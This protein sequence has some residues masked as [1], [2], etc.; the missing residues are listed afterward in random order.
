MPKHETPFY[1]KLKELYAT[2][3]TLATLARAAILKELRELRSAK[4]V[5]D[6]WAW[7]GFA[8]YIEKT[9]PELEVDFS[10]FSMAGEG[11]WEDFDWTFLGGPAK[12]GH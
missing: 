7:K 4:P 8:S 2:D 3:P 1:D 6:N 9:Y 12:I 5:T 11:Y 10:N